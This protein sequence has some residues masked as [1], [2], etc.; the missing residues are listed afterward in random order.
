MNVKGTAIRS[1]LDFLRETCGPEGLEKVLAA[2][3]AEDRRALE[4]ALPTSW[5]PVELV[6]R[7]DLEIVRQGGGLHPAREYGAFSARRNLTRVYKVFLDQAAGDPQL[8]LQSLVP[9]HASFYDE[10]SMCLQDAERGS[11]GIELDFAGRAARFRCQVSL[12]FVEQA[13]RMLDVRDLQIQETGCQTRGSARCAFSVRW[14]P[15]A[16]LRPAVRAT[17]APGPRMTTSLR[18]GGTS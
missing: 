9:L 15:D 1:R 2:L 5:I 13:L 10:G 11:C 3:P 18:A 17:G 12:G 4:G 6:D 7:L 8:L 16:T 14:S